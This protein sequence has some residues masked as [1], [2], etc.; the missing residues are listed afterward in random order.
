M[1]A[2]TT[3]AAAAGL[4]AT[5]AGTG[6]SFLQARKQKKA[7]SAA[8]SKAAESMLKARE[9]LEVNYFDALAIQKEPYEQ[10]REA[11]LS[12]GAMGMQAGVEG[13]QRGAAATAGRIQAA[14]AQ[15]QAGVR[16]AMG[17]ELLGLEKLSAEEDARLRDMQA[18][19]DLAEVEGAQMAQAQAEEARQKALS[20]GIQGTISA[21]GQAAAMVPLYQN[22]VKAQK[23]AASQVESP[24]TGGSFMDMSNREFK[25]YMKQNPK[26]ATSMMQNPEYA[27]QLQNYMQNPAAYKFYSPTT[28]EDEVNQ[29][30]EQNPIYSQIITQNPFSF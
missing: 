24:T 23:F 4:A 27:K 20:E 21:V 19:L 11:L 26:I 10:E 22:N 5:A 12:Q 9:R 2:F 14:Q 7:A 25:Q 28:G 29:W 13:A 17:Q 3:I 18:S 30:M 15:A 16:T 6:A 1:A 8:A